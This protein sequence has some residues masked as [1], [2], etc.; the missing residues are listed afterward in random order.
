MVEHNLPLLCPAGNC[1]VYAAWIEPRKY[2][3][4]SDLCLAASPQP[5]VTWTWKNQLWELVTILLE[6]QEKVR[7]AH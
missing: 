5:G 2:Q 6:C 3:L 7:F 1:G 4:Q